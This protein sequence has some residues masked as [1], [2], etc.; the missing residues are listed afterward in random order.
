V[1]ACSSPHWQ[2]LH[3][4]LVR[5]KS[6][7]PGKLGSVL[8]LP[9]PIEEDDTDYSLVVP[10]KMPDGDVEIGFS[11]KR[12][13]WGKGFATEACRRLLDFAFQETPLEVVVATFEIENIASKHVL[14][15]VGFSNHGTRHCYGETSP[16]FRM[17]RIQW[18]R[19]QR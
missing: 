2:W 8:L 13:A 4:D 14:D 9:L 6:E 17:T 5:H 10:G 15:K 12:S 11:L 7:N 19:M 3:W 18:S 16:D 1:N